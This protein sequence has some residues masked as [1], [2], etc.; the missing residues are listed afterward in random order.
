MK[1]D[2]IIY[3][4]VP[5]LVGVGNYFISKN[6]IYSII[7]FVIYLAF[8]F[9]FVAY[10]RNKYKRNINRSY[11]A[12]NYINNFIISL[13]VSKSFNNAFDNAK[14][15][16]SKELRLQID[17]I[18]YIPIESRIEYLY[19]YFEIP[20]YGVFINIIHQYVFNG[21][22]I[23]EISQ[24]LIRDSRALEERLRDYEVQIKRKFI[25]FLVAWGLTTV[26]LFALHFS[27]QSLGRALY[28]IDVYPLL[29]FIYFLLVLFNL[30]LIL[31]KMYDLS[32]ITKDDSYA[33]K[34]KIKN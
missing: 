24:L 33:K 17:A 1:L 15:S 4:L 34:V 14:N 22:D 19:R 21:G 25:E 20:I 30:Y 27:I 8:F 11:E 5:A 32:F 3:I 7:L 12:V 16:A 26:I 6:L 29:I 13:S 23:L 18:D 9:L 10:K 28:S 31:N 2:L